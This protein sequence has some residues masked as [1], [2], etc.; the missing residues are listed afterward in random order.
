MTC[1]IY[2]QEGF[3]PSA[4]PQSRRYRDLIFIFVPLLDCSHSS[5]LDSCV[6]DQ[7]PPERWVD[8]FMLQPLVY[9]ISFRVRLKVPL[10]VP[11]ILKISS[12]TATSQ[13]IYKTWASS[14]RILFIRES[15]FSIKG[16]Q[17]RCMF[18]VTSSKILMTSLWLFL[19][20]YSPTTRNHHL[21]QP[22]RRLFPQSRESHEENLQSWC[23]FLRYWISSLNYF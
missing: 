18:K 12:Q 19:K 8:N 5:D 23:T 11:N 6:G 14:W 4:H 2:L 20:K 7:K 10:V 22:H 3:G 21:Q 17:I 9:F 16:E 1:V 15:H 13:V